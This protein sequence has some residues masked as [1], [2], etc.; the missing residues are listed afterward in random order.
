MIRFRSFHMSFGS[1]NRGR[2]HW[3]GGSGSRRAT[4]E[5]RQPEARQLGERGDLGE[6]RAPPAD[7]IAAVEPPEKQEEDDARHEAQGPRRPPRD[8]LGQRV[9]R[10][11][12]HPCPANTRAGSTCEARR[13]GSHAPAIAAITPSPT[14]SR[15]SQSGT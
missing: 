11:L 2:S 12:R 1:W 9:R 8:W 15:G 13:A 3:N 6:L 10:T 5:Q 14:P 7:Q 4:A